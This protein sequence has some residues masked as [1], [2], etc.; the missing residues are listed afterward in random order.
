MASI[1]KRYRTYKG[2]KVFDGWGLRTQKITGKEIAFHAPA[3]R[4]EES[5]VFKMKEIIEAVEIAFSKGKAA[6]SETIADVQAFGDTPFTEWLMKFGI[7]APVKILS[8]DGLLEMALE[9]FKELGTKPQTLHR[10]RIGGE[11]FSEFLQEKGLDIPVSAIDKKLAREFWAWLKD[12]REA[13]GWTPATVNKYLSY[14]KQVFKWGAK[15]LDDLTGNP[16]DCVDRIV[17]TRDK[18]KKYVTDEQAAQVLKALE[19][20]NK[21]Q[22]WTAIFWLGYR[23]GLRV[24]SEAPRLRWGFVDFEGRR[25][26]IEDVKRSKRGAKKTREMILDD[27]TAE[28]LRR[29]RDYRRENGETTREQDYIFPEFVG[30]AETSVSHGL[31]YALKNAGI[32][33]TVNVGTMR[34][35]ASNYWGETVGEFWE[36][37]FL[38]HSKEISR[39]HY[40][41]EGVTKN[42]F[43]LYDKAKA[44]KE[45]LETC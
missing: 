15:H 12:K 1:T 11:Y 28:A 39:T 29:L 8:F 19:S 32:K 23:Q 43:D 38:G 35:A 42:A 24:W 33:T 5:D 36:N 41:T 14:I 21:S 2:S 26:M 13:N 30:K 16:F 34:R 10:I 22:L 27:Q 45:T 3:T 25:L 17:D 4:Y 37:T 44:E 7:V 40:R 18:A 20:S 6:S 9:G 31:E